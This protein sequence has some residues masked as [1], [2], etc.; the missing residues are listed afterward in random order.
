MKSKTI[1]I[2]SLN[3]NSV[4]R[5]CITNDIA[6]T[7]AQRSDSYINELYLFTALFNTI[8]NFIHE[9]EIDCKKANQWFLNTYNAEI[10]DF[11]MIKYI[12]T[13]IKKPIMTTY[14]IYYTKILLLILIPIAQWYDSFSKKLHL[15]K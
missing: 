15:I 5:I 13:E 14:F 7:F 6:Y 3:V 12:S 8:P 9:K 4:D 10:K 1:D 2:N 11:F